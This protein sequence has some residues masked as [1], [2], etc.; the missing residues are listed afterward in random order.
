MNNF[1]TAFKIFS[2]VLK[3][4]NNWSIFIQNLW[5]INAPVRSGNI[6]KDTVVAVCSKLTTITFTVID[7]L[8]FCLG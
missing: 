2:Q 1:T 4:S 5:L 7:I 3:I 8:T 6:Y